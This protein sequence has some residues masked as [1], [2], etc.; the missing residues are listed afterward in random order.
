[1]YHLNDE[2]E[3]MSPEDEEMDFMNF[4]NSDDEDEDYEDDDSEED[5][6]DEDD[7]SD[8]DDEDEDV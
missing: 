5:D 8:D 7:Y 1:M 2:L 6:S 4:G 3:I